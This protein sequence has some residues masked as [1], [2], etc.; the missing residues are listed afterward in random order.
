VRPGL[1]LS[2]DA[3][4]PLP[5]Q[6]PG[7][8]NTIVQ[9]PL[10]LLA[11]T[12]SDV[13]ATLPARYITLTYQVPRE[14]N[15]CVQ[16]L[17]VFSPSARSDPGLELGD[18]LSALTADTGTYSV[19]GQDAPLLSILKSGGTNYAR[20]RLLVDPAGCGTTCLSLANDLS[21][22]SEA[23]AAGMKILLDIECSDSPTSAAAQATPAAWAGQPL[24]QLASTVQA[25]TQSVIRSFA[26]NGTP[27][28]QVAIGNEIT[29]GMLWQFTRLATASAA[30]AP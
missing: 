4:Q 29:Q 24:P 11:G 23:T 1:G 8:R 12:T 27:V 7:D 14:Q 26:M 30:A 21:I 2:A 9:G 22:A 13:R 10:Y 5:N 3:E 19:N 16:E 20:L 17:R 25:Y 6:A 28:S 18:D 15:I